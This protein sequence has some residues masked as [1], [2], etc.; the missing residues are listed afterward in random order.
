[1]T[2]SAQ[3]GSLTAAS[4]PPAQSPRSLS[5]SAMIISAAAIRYPPFDA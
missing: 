2:A 5:D 3:R 4:D 1:M